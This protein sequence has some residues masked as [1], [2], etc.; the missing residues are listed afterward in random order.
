MKSSN[1]RPSVMLALLSGSAALFGQTAVQLAAPGMLVDPPPA[2]GVFPAGL[3]G[4]VTLGAYNLRAVKGQPYSLLQTT[5]TIKTLADGTTI[6]NVMEERIM[7]DAEGRERR[8][9]GLMKDGKLKVM[10]VF[11]TDPVENQTVMLS[12]FDKSARV[13]HV[14][15]PQPLQ[16]P[17][18]PTAE[19]QAKMEEM[20]TK[21]EAY[22]KEHPA[23]NIEKLTGQNIAGVYAEG[24]HQTMVIPAGKMGN[25]RD[26]HVETETWTSPDL[27]IVVLSKTDDPRLGKIT[28]EVSEL[29]RV[30]PDPSLFLIPSDYKV[31]EQK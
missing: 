25:D 6:T 17:T 5:T 27:K 3:L 4:G 1:F 13:R 11:L 29:Q 10:N 9:T 12:S 19:Q 16:P 26:I 7:R 22:R 18:P 24:M 30:D 23:P 28:R 21:A 15:R 2:P 8:E 20:R 14:P 31:I